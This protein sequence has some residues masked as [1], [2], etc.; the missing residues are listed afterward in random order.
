MVFQPHLGRAKFWEI[1]CQQLAGFA[2]VFL[3][4]RAGEPIR[5]LLL[6]A[7]PSFPVADIFGIGY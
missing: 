6:A 5:P 1:Y 4:G 3:L 7:G 2:A